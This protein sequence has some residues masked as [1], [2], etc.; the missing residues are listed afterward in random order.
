MPASEAA[1]LGTFIQSIQAYLL[2]EFT[3][4]MRLLVRTMNVSQFDP[5]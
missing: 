5:Y 2:K 1:E 3:T 4:G